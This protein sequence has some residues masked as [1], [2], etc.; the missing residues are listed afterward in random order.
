MRRATE[1]RQL[2]EMML[3]MNL[4]FLQILIRTEAST[5]INGPNTEIPRHPH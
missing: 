4:L 5:D 3:A 2:V 1:A